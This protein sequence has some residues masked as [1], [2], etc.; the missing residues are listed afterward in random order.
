MPE[1]LDRVLRAIGRTVLDAHPCLRLGDELTQLGEQ[2]VGGR[3]APVERLDPLQPLEHRPRL[4]HHPKVAGKVFPRRAVYVPTSYTRAVIVCPNC[5]EENPERA[6]FCLNCGTALG[7]AASGEERKVVSVLFVDLVG[8]TAGADRADPEDV[9]A[10]LRPYHERV[11]R[12]IE[13]FGGTVEKFVGDAVMAVFGAPVAYEDDPE[14]AV[15]AGL[16][17][18]DAIGELSE[19]E[20][21]ELAVR[22]AVA[23]GE[24]V[25]QLG[26]QPGT[27]EGIATGDVVNTAARLQGAAPVGGLIVNEQTYRATGQAIRYQELPEL[28]LKGKG[29]P[30]RAWQV[31]SARSRFG[32]DAEAA[33]PTL[34][35]GRAREL[36]LLQDT[37]ERMVGE[38]EIQLVT[39]A[40]EPGVG[41]TRLLAE[42]RA[43]VD[44]RHELVYWRQGRCL[45]Y[46][47]GIT[48]WALGEIVKAHAG[49]LES[50]TPEDADAKLDEAVAGADDADW[51]QARLGPL[52]GLTGAGETDR[53]DSFRAWQRFIE[54]IAARGPLVLL[55]EDLHWADDALLEFVERLVD[56]SSGL[57]ILVLSTGRPELYERHPAWGG[58]KRNSTTV[59]LSPLS[60][61][62]TARL[63]AA[64]LDTAVLPAETQA[65][66]LER[67]GGNPLYAEEYARL[68]LE[69]GSA[70]KLP[71]PDTVQGLIAARLDTLPQDRKALLQDA[72][73]VGKVFWAGAL[74][75]IGERGGEDVREGLHQL[76]RKELLRPARLSSVEGQT[77]YAFWHALIRD[78]AYGQ[79]P[80]GARALKHEAAADWLE[81]MAG[82]RV[83][84]HADLLAYH[85]TEALAL[86][87][88]AGERTDHE[89]ELRAARY[90]VLAGDRAIELDV[91][92]A[93]AR[94]RRALE[95]LPPGSEEHGLTLQKLAETAQAEGAFEQAREHAEA[96]ASELEAIGAAESAARAYSLVGN[97]YFQLGGADRM[98]AALERSLELLEPLPPG[99]EHVET[100]GRMASL[101]SM[102][103]GSPQLGLDWAEKAISL[104]EELRLPREL[105]RAY[106]WRGLMRCE[107][108]DLA[109]I[110]DLE[111]GL[112]MSLEFRHIG[113]IPAYVN[114]ADQVWRQ[115][116]P[117]AA[118]EIQTTAIEFA[119]RRGGTPT[120][121]MAESC[122]MLYDLGRWDELLQV[123]ENIRSFEETR[124]AAQPGAM[125]QGYAAFVLIRRGAIEASATVV[126]NALARSRKIEDPQV[127]GP[128]LVASALVA[129]AI[130]D[131][132]G[133]VSAVE[134]YRHV[135]RNR[136]Y[137][138]AQNLTD[139]ARV[140]CA[141]GDI[142]LAEGL[143]DNVVTAAERDR[144]SALTV[145]ATISGAKG[146]YAEAAAGWSALG[147]RLEHALALRR[148]GKEDAANAILEELGVPLPPAQTAARTAK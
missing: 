19:E 107:L 4:V 118:L 25:V 18:L 110:D 138:R 80:R 10:T 15:R 35:V 139:A 14:R 30:V 11:S 12:E 84:D 146:L 65:A 63:V 68:F 125:A 119:E 132:S 3:A 50:D 108:G 28:D 87:S 90:L 130:G 71:L 38:S 75:S 115:R 91:G 105:S 136:P 142:A 16:R 70:E 148:T 128:A 56:W 37:F 127:L 66:L 99:P 79:I 81:Q 9:R 104:G 124:G 117:A 62:E 33:P 95:L 96:A 49:I 76:A 114:L 40:G 131:A 43:W 134:E 106:Q 22:A 97:V 147:C 57:P 144:L 78:V 69:L 98:R 41:K 74:E 54:S 86:A 42:F 113:V 103:G 93:A 44:D 67:A 32:V 23:T 48:F 92:A 58:G 24:A 51:L 82:D 116:G 2:D 143:L 60:Q 20:G 145:Q 129:E 64:L 123:A 45:P 55:F 27:G 141:A 140:A 85:T 135:T 111:R 39:I 13:R 102:S 94:Y 73:V 29:A 47:D 133:A 121:P 17:I 109:G 126:A 120:W 61:E 100:Y 31:L 6:R 26:A 34:F 89:L 8:F 88:A 112:A 5:Q 7:P 72:A 122:W 53:E 137:F 1:T 101:E 77:E 46:G 59:A 36:R 83:A 21:L 52:V